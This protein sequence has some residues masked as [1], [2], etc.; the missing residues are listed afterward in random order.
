M[1]TATAPRAPRSDARRASSVWG[2]ADST[3]SRR[4]SASAS[5]S[6]GA[7]PK[8][9]SRSADALSPGEV[10]GRGPALG[11]LRERAHLVRAELQP[12]A[13]QQPLGLGGVH[14]QVA[15]PQLGHVPMRPQPRERQL[16]L[17]ARC[18]GERR[19]GR[20]LGQHLVHELP[21][22]LGLEQ[23]GVVQR[24]HVA[25]VAPAVRPRHEGVNVGGVVQARRRYRSEPDERPL[26]GIG[27]FGEQSRFAVAR[28]RHDEDQD[29]LGL[30]GQA[31]DER[32]TRHESG[33][34]R[35]RIR[36]KLGQS[37]G[38]RVRRNAIVAGR[39]AAT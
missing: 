11:A 20:E 1:P 5:P 6:P 18:Q 32:G 7:Q 37:I 29:G 9:A 31:A 27:P 23:M 26:I 19:A 14:R 33:W 21:E 22:K 36:R 4:Y 24:E 2:S 3:S 28:R 10:Q 12:G 38:Q 17:S 16:E 30:A 13:G 8:F 39:R 34:E 15:R 35:R 25:R